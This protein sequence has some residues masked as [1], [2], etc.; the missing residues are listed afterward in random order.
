MIIHELIPD[1]SFQSVF[2]TERRGETGLTDL[3]GAED[4][5]GA[6][7]LDPDRTDRQLLAQKK[8]QKVKTAAADHAQ[9]VGD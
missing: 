9:P 1:R 8:G 6:K 3:V 4:G 2:Q 5:L 7:L